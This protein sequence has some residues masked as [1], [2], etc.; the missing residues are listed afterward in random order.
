MSV[1]I[2]NA[3]EIEMKHYRVKFYPADDT[4]TV[5]DAGTYAANNKADAIQ[6]AKADNSTGPQASIFAQPGIWRASK[7]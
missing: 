2:E 5:I 1:G 4:N 6:C 3:K 7:L